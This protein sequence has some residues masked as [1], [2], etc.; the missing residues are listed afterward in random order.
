MCATADRPV[1]ANGRGNS[2]PDGNRDLAGANDREE[3]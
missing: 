3:E 1:Q 2:F